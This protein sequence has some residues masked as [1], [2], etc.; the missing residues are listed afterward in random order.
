MVDIKKPITIGKN[1][2]GPFNESTKELSKRFEVLETYFSSLLIKN[3]ANT[4]ALRKRYNDLC[5]SFGSSYTPDTYV[6]DRQIGEM[7]YGGGTDLRAGGCTDFKSR[8]D[9]CRIYTAKVDKVGNITG[10]SKE[11][12]CSKSG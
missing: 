8:C 9:V 3:F 10:F 4:G 2:N 6:S 11:A 12:I 5:R 1:F 7:F